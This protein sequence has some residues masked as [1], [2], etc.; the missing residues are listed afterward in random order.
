M[1]TSGVASYRRLLP[2]VLSFVLA[3]GASE[4]ASGGGDAPAAPAG[5]YIA[6][7]YAIVTS[8]YQAAAD[9]LTQALAGDPT[10]SDI[11]G[12]ALLSYIALGDWDRARAIAATLSLTKQ[13]NSLVDLV[14][15]AGL[16]QDEKYADAVA[17]LDKGRTAG[18]L[19]DG[20]FRGWALVGA[21]QMGDALKAFDKV[22]EDKGLRPFALQQKA[23]ALASVGDFEAADK[24]LSSD[25]AKAFAQSRRGL[26]AHAQILSQLERDKDALKLLDAMAGPA[27]QDR[28]LASIRQ[29]LVEGKT[30]PFT[31]IRSA[32]DGL[33]ELFLA[34][35]S[36]LS[37]EPAPKDLP[38]D[39]ARPQ[40]ADVLM[41]ARTAK[42]L[43]P[44]LADADLL[45]AATVQEQKQNALAISVLRQI[46]PAGPMGIEAQ[47]GL[48]N[49]LVSDGQLDEA[50]QVLKALTAA[51]PDRPDTWAAL[52]DVQRRAERY[53]DGADAY[54]RALATI[55]AP[56]TEQ[57]VLF[58][59]R[60][61]CYERMKDW[62]KAE[63]DFRKALELS[64][65]QPDVLNYLGYS[66]LEKTTNY[67]EALQMI[68]KAAKAVPD[69]G[70]IA[71]SLG[72]AY[73]RTGDYPKAE[74][75]MERAINLMPND[76]VVND[77]LGDVYW[78]VGRKTEA[79]F[80][81]R[82]A[83]S[84]KPDPEDAARIRRKLEVGLDAVLKEEA[85]KGGNGTAGSTTNGNG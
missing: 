19:V 85:A 76:P 71:D 64:P 24:I 55:G 35:G 13:T 67:T 59:A 27:P 16:V 58:Y 68:A 39:Q 5:A 48:A 25:D 31:L 26:I 7:R 72:W 77:H 46:D 69:S 37:T 20:I 12:S 11:A 83:Q 56:K 70:A 50:I 38:P 51:V 57:W 32:K 15:L 34:V 74:V 45:I 2:L 1:G 47:Y 66:L 23:L 28:E 49:A 30:V 8:D 54:S 40:T 62:T 22:A 9:Y 43:R 73:Y 17:A 14:T 75:E 80:Q 60:G 61:I 10:N 33:A 84:F 42:Y 63:A 18:P 21:G 6:G 3:A 52:G 4:G 81:W 36:I 41:F 29:A 82:R 78:M 44:D 79:V 53:A 65:D